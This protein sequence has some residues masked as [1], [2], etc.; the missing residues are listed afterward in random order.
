MKRVVTKCGIIE[1]SKL[2]AHHRKGAVLLGKILLRVLCAL[3]FTGCASVPHADTN[4]TTLVTG[5]LYFAGKNFPS[6]ATGTLSLNQTFYDGIEITLKNLETGK[7]YKTKTSSNGLF[8]VSNVQAGTYKISKISLQISD[9]SMKV[10]FD[11]AEWMGDPVFQIT[12]NSAN[13]MGNIEW[14][15][16][17]IL[18]GQASAELRLLGEYDKVRRDF[19]RAFPSS[20]WNDQS[21]MPVPYV[22]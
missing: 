7:R 15:N 14:L 5:M 17:H 18:K 2:P 12:S 11:R 10:K 16:I 3:A 22:W 4:T 20:N 19:K 9:H 21:W 8:Y 1:G 13:N 6:L